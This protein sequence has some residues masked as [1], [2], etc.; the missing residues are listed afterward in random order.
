MKQ[1]NQLLKRFLDIIL[2]L[3]SLLLIWWLLILLIII[4]SIDTKHFGLFTQKRVGKHANLFSMFKIRTMTVSKN[5]ST[6]TTLKDPRI[7]P[8]GSLLRKY[9]LDELPQLVNVLIG[10][11]SFVGPRPDVIGFADELKGEDQIILS[12]K[13]GITGPASVYFKNEESLLAQQEN[14]EVYN[15]NVIWP[16]KVEINKEYIKNYSIFNDMK[17]IIKTIIG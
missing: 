4:S 11:M 12:I 3:F 5:K 8:F 10:N 9:K 7:T 6:V 14:P 15:R 16:K 17:Y 2:S 13:P 1:S